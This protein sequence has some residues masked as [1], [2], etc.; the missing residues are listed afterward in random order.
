[1]TVSSGAATVFVWLVNLT[2]IGGFIG[3]WVIN[4]TYLCFRKSCSPVRRRKLTISH[5]LRIQE[6]GVRQEGTRLLQ[7]PSAIS[8]LVG[9]LLD[10]DL[11]RYLWSPDM[12]QLEHFYLP[13]LL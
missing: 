12:V 11:P 1:M 13:Y 2:T 5:R 7:F 6:T 3:W 10:I 4:C 8:L 9:Y